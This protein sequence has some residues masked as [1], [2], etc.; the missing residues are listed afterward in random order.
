MQPASGVVIVVCRVSSNYRCRIRLFGFR[1]LLKNGSDPLSKSFLSDTMWTGPTLAAWHFS[2]QPHPTLHSPPQ[3][4]SSLFSLLFQRPKSGGRWPVRADQFSPSA[5]LKW[6][7][8]ERGW[9][10]MKASADRSP[11]SLPFHN[12]CGDLSFVYNPQDTH[13]PIYCLLLQ[14]VSQ[15]GPVA[16]LSLPTPLRCKTLARCMHRR[17][18]V[19]SS[20]FRPKPGE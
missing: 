3:F 13:R 19:F 11:P 20:F 10:W 5:R 2:V 18:R 15:A 1:I 7:E 4:P 14:A 9:D 12:R 6:R 17:A 8:G 16:S